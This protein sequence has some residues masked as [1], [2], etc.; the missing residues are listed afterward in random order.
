MENLYDVVVVGGGVVG[1]AVA[2]ELSRYQLKICVL[3]KELDVCNGVSGRNT[4]LLHSGILS[5]DQPVRTECCIEGK[6]GIRPGGEGA[7][8]PVQAVREADRGLWGGR[9]AVPSAAV[10]ATG[11]NAAF[12][13]SA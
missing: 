4:G 7:G 3:E 10:P 2:R 1:S 12:P 5:G 8:R 9:K 6:R 13:A 11:W